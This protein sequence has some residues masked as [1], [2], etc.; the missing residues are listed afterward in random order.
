MSYMN[1]LFAFILAYVIVHFSIPVLK[2]FAIRIDFVD[3]PT[4]RKAH[5]NPVPHLASIG[6][7]AGFVIAYFS[8]TKSIGREDIGFLI[9]SF[10]IIGIGLVDDWFKTKEKEFPP[11]PKFLVQVGAAAIAYF[12]GAVFY[13]FTNPFTDQFV[14][15]PTILQFSLSVTWV[16]G[17][18][19]VINFIDGLDGL[20]GGISAIS[21]ATLFV[22]ALA[23]GQP[24]SA[25]MAIVLVAVLIGYLKYNKQPAQIYMGDAGATFIGYT[26]GIIALEGAFKQATLLSV[27]IPILALG[28]PI[29]DNVFVVLKRIMNGKPPYQADR[30]HAHHRLLSAGLKPSQVVIFLCLANLCFGLFS[31]IITLLQG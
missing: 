6:I 16:F 12:S 22:V 14:V 24:Q 21:A 23:K 30:T 20:A 29:F 25:M 15:L 9:G 2:K 8:F 26:L 17:V 19:T 18:T 31:I 7:Y 27:A 4:N 28:V 1:Y 10:L 13:G 3:R 11:L 5:A